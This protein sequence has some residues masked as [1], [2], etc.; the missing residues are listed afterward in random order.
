MGLCYQRN[1]HHVNR[2]EYARVVIEL[3]CE[4]R[5]KV[6]IRARMNLSMVDGETTG[7]RA[8]STPTF[9]VDTNSPAPIAAAFYTCTRTSNSIVS[10]IE[11]AAS[12]LLYELKVCKLRTRT[13][14]GSNGRKPSELVLI[15]RPGIMQTDIPSIT[16]MDYPR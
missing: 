15:L 9:D 13:H 3:H 16:R 8:E 1:G 11:M 4:L 2:R 6:R 12:Q 10:M 7:N 14:K 5:N